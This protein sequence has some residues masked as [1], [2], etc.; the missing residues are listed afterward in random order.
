MA[1]NYTSSVG[2]VFSDSSIR[3]VYGN[4]RIAPLMSTD[5][6]I[7]SVLEIFSRSTS[8]D[9]ALRIY[10]T[11]RQSRKTADPV[12]SYLRQ[13]GFGLQTHRNAML[14]M[15]N[16]IF[17]CPSESLYKACEVA[18]EGS[19]SDASSRRGGKEIM[20]ALG[21]LDLTDLSHADHS[22]ANSMLSHY[23]SKDV[24]Y[25]DLTLEQ[26]TALVKSLF[27]RGILTIP[28]GAINFGDFKRLIPFCP[29]Y[30]YTRGEPIDRYYLNKFIEEI[31][32]DVVGNT[33][34]IGGNR[35]NRR[36]YN[37]MRTT[38]YRAL[39]L[40]GGA[41]VDIIGDAH[42]SHIVPYNSLDSIIIFNVL[43]H[44]ERP[45]VVVE[46][47]YNWLKDGGKVFCVVPNAQ[48]VHKTPKD[49]WRPLP[50]AMDS[51]FAK[52]L[53]RKSISYGNPIATVG[54]MM[55][56]AAEELSSEELDSVNNEYPVVTCV[57]AQKAAAH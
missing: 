46:N 11:L 27:T 4:N 55:G 2:L 43:E 18:V 10:K 42:D 17:V 50:D 38:S 45:W 6:Y 48:R 57:F 30:G 9:E 41:G 23:L 1:S 13:D 8:I 35:L 25:P 39:D 36:L 32:D 21:I 24:E 19:I 33:L 12:A 3:M 7:P 49:F 37:F 44:C 52:F 47:I 40:S 14:L 31:R 5:Y 34:E 26:I 29:E 53:I 51:L 28:V 20:D 22:V 15:Q 56:I 54:S 16:K